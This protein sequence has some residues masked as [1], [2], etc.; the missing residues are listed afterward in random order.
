MVQL[1]MS[2]LPDLQCTAN[3]YS[4]DGPRALWSASDRSHGHNEYARLRRFSYITQAHCLLSAWPEYCMLHNKNALGIAKFIFEDI[5]CRHG[6]IEVIV[7]NNGVPYIAALDV[8]RDCYG[9]NH[10]HI[11]P[12]NS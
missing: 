12:Y 7:T 1:D 6:A 4:A 10:I 11:S 5:L 9:I 8:L 2:Y 3:P